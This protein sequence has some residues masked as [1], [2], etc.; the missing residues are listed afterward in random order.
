MIYT[1]SLFFGL[2]F[3]IT[4]VLAVRRQKLHFLYA[5]LWLILALIIILIP[6]TVSFWNRLAHVLGVEYGPSLIFLCAILF[7]I[8]YIYNLTI[9]V[10]RLS[11]KTTRLIQEIGLLKQQIEENRGLLND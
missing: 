5:F 1:L 2:I 9:T 3:A 6:V 8:V 10:S 7:L 4:T 11:I